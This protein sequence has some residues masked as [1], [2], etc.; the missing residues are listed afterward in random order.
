MGDNENITEEPWCLDTMGFERH[1][2]RLLPPNL[3]THNQYSMWGGLQTQIPSTPQACQ[4]RVS[5]NI[6]LESVFSSISQVILIHN[7]I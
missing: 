3:A 1:P 6:A 7:Q 2:P 5:R 4:V